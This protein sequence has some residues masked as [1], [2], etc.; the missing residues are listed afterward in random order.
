MITTIKRPPR[1]HAIDVY[2]CVLSRQG[3]LTWLDASH[4]RWR[5]VVDDKTGDELEVRFEKSKTLWAVAAVDD[6]LYVAPR[7]VSDPRVGA[8]VVMGLVDDGRSVRIFPTRGD[9]IPDG[10]VGV[11]RSPYRK[12]RKKRAA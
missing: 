3:A 5:K 6:R 9:V 1:E 8:Y 12:P 2:R 7:D 10:E 4:G 11:M